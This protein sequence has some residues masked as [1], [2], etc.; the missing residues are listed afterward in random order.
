MLLILAAEEK[1]HQMSDQGCLCTTDKA[2]AGFLLANLAVTFPFNGPLVVPTKASLSLE[3]K[4]SNKYL[5]LVY[6]LISFPI[7]PESL[8]K[9]RSE[10][11][12][13]VRSTCQWWHDHELLN[14]EHL[15]LY[16]H[17]SLSHLRNLGHWWR[18]TGSSW[19]THSNRV[20]RTANPE[21][22]RPKHSGILKS[23][24]GKT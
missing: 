3:E 6:Y 24:P 16:L 12:L 4:T 17:L 8:S 23:L 22:S 14:D 18:P 2:K 10:P 13:G 20:S 15:T 11:P 19:V 21:G 1:F 9:Y 7:I 5:S